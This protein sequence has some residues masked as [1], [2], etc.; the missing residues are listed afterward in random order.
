M[1]VP[2]PE[3]MGYNPNSVAGVY[4]NKDALWS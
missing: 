1:G 3:Y 4:Y 2:L